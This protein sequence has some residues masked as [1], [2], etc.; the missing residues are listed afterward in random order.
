MEFIKHLERV[1]DSGVLLDG[2]PRIPSKGATKDMICREEKVMPRS[3][4]EQHKL[5]LKSWNGANFD[6]MR[7]YGV[8]DVESSFIR[9]L[10][11]ENRE[12]D[13]IINEVGNKAILFADDISGFMYFELFDRTI[14]QLDTDGGEMEVVA[15]DMSDFFLNYLFG[16]RA[17]EYAGKD[18]L[19]E[20]KEAKLV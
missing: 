13:E 12:W 10:E 4:S 19:D 14:T 18:W 6:F 1:I 16:K 7:V 20:L 11:K 15:D 9:I 2:F 17:E 8:H 3:L 5:F